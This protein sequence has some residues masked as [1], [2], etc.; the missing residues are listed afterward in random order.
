[1]E[2][3]KANSVDRQQEIRD[4][5]FDISADKSVLNYGKIKVGTKTLEEAVLNLGSLKSGDR[6]YANK[7]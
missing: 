7:D 6:K 1:M 2:E 4:K 3:I 5:G